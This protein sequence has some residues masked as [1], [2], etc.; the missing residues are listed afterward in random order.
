[1]GNN[2]T[3]PFDLETAKKIMSGELNGSIVTTTEKHKVEIVYQEEGSV[4]PILAV[5]HS[6]DGPTSDWFSLS[7]I[8]FNFMIELKVPEYTTFKDGDVL[9]DKDGNFIF[10]LNTNGKF[11]TSFYSS[12]DRIGILCMDEG[13]AANQNNIQK[14]RLATQS[15]KQK[16]I[17]ALK[18]SDEPKAALYLKKFFGIEKEYDFKP[19]DKVLV[20]NDANDKWHISLFTRKIIDKSNSKIYKYECANGTKWNYCIPFAGNENSME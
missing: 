8:G 19:F 4:R 14:Y 6:D 1:M 7:G 3:I 10:I 2:I 5:I 18:A 13:Y 11:L 17:N 12:L 9:S 16:M 20:K 15:E